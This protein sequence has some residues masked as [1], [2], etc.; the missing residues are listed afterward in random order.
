MAAKRLSIFTFAKSGGAG[1]VSIL[2]SKLLQEQGVNARVVTRTDNGLR[3]SAK[4]IIDFS[5]LPLI[6]LAFIDRYVVRKSSWKS[7]FSLF[8]DLYKSRVV[9]PRNQESAAVLRWTAGFVDFKSL[10]KKGYSNFILIPPDYFPFTGGCHYSLGCEQF[11]KDCSECP[12][13]RK[14]FRP[15][16][17]KNHNKKLMQA[18]EFGDKVKVVYPSNGVREKLSHTPIGKAFR[19]S[20]VIPHP[21]DSEFIGMSK[22]R[23]GEGGRKISVI[24]VAENLDDPIKGVENTIQS[25]SRTRRAFNLTLV[26]HSDVLQKKY[27]K[28]NDFITFTGHL[29]QDKIIKNLLDSDIFLVASEEEYFGSAALQ[30]LACGLP[31]MSTQDSGAYFMCEDLGVERGIDKNKG[32]EVQI[33]EF[34]KN[35]DFQ[36]MKSKIRNL[37]FGYRNQEIVVS[38]MDIIIR[39]NN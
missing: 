21:L 23:S 32:L 35:T 37:Q 20:R 33:R 10:S 39:S 6:F 12:A 25:L 27:G 29:P 3:G 16:V 30:A 8:R 31:V 34:V 4:S 11:K 2:L 9:P 28:T 38:Y 18:K 7:E 14:L 15:L 13:V 19:E 24:L 1:R 5:L 17:S 26:G 22:A 36:N